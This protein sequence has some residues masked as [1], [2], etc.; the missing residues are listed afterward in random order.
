[1]TSER[2]FQNWPSWFKVDGH[3][4]KKWTTREVNGHTISED[5]TVD[6]NKPNWKVL[7]WAR[8]PFDGKLPV[9]WAKLHRHVRKTDVIRL[10]IWSVH[11]LRDQIDLI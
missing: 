7:R 6:D 4:G 9:F 10:K 3:K 8:W 11:F 1:M 2:S 5:P